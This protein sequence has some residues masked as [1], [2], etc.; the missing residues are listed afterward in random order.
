MN[1]VLSSSL[2]SL[3]LLFLL[4]HCVHS[5]R[6]DSTQQLKFQILDTYIY[7]ERVS[8]MESYNAKVFVPFLFEAVLLHLAA[9]RVWLQTGVVLP[10]P[11]PTS[12]VETAVGCS[13]LQTPRCSLQAAGRFHQ[14]NSLSQH[15]IQP[16]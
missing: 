5:T 15:G 3:S 6:L 8:I 1:S 13:T 7:R 2:F 12:G 14:Q 11:T 9:D 4:M 16:T 10:T